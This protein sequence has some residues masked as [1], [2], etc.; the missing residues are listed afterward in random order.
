MGVL[1]FFVAIASFGILSLPSLSDVVAYVLSPSLAGIFAG[2]FWLYNH[3][4]WRFI[5]D[6][7]L[8]E[9]NRWRV[10]RTG[11]DPVPDLAGR[12]QGCVY[13]EDPVIKGLLGSPGSAFMT[14]DQTWSDILISFESSASTS[15]SLNAHVERL[16]TGK[17]RLIYVYYAEPSDPTRANVMSPHYGTAVQYFE[18]NSDSFDGYYY[19]ASQPLHSGRLAFNRSEI[20]ERSTASPRVPLRLIVDCD[21]GIDDALA[22]LL[23]A[24]SHRTH[25]LA[26]ELITVTS[27]NVSVHQAAANARRVMASS[28]LEDIP[29]ILGGNSTL[30]GTAMVDAIAFHGEGGLGPFR[31]S[32]ETPAGTEADKAP[33]A[34]ISTVTRISSQGHPCQILCLGPLTNLA[35]AILIEP[36]IVKRIDSCTIMGGA[37]GNPA[38]NVT[39]FAEFNLWS[40]PIAARLVLESGMPIR[41]VPLDTTHKTALDERDIN[42]LDCDNQISSLLH[43]SLDLHRR[44]GS[45]AAV[46]HDAVA[47]LAVIRP[48][49]FKVEPKLIKFHYQGSMAGRTEMLPAEPGVPVSFVD[50]IDPTALRNALLSALS[51]IPKLAPLVTDDSDST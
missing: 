20:S 21:P 26:L 43:S 23:L 17:I 40:D 49:Q 36:S 34:I 9:G 6:K 45:D 1:M 46:I 13:T 37:F 15:H 8:T 12:Y 5:N 24:T 7:Y 32:A 44:S 28:G 41:L 48:D 14:I 4:G 18:P 39:D 31:I 3:W 22:L 47:A 29:L 38:G 10:L 16:P 50:A 27:G 35:R 25:E 30:V 33:H 51:S 11:L 2:L 19:T 42:S